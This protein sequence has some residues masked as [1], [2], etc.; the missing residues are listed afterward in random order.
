MEQLK[1]N[2]EQNIGILEDVFS[3]LVMWNVKDGFQL[4]SNHISDVNKTISNLLSCKPQLEKHGILVDETFVLEQLHYL[5]E[6]LEYKDELLLIDAI[7]YAMLPMLTAY[8]N[9]I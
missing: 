8:Y 5:V 9:E 2:I 4:I 1:L 7:E 6:A 3:Q